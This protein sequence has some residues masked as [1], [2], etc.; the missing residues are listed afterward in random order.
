MSELLADYERK[1]R[2]AVLHLDALGE[3]VKGFT[4]RE[5]GPIKGEPQPNG[6]EYEF[7][8]PPER[9]HPNWQLLIGEFAY[10]MRASL[11]YLITA[12]VRSTGNEESKR[13][14]FP[15]YSPPFGSVTFADVHDWWDSSAKVGKQ[16]E[17]T[18]SGTRAALKQLQPFYGLPVTDHVRH[19]LNALYELN[20]RV[21]HRSLNLIARAATLK[22]ID[23]DG[24]PLFQGL[25]F[26]FRSVPTERNEAHTSDVYLSV[27][28]D[29]TEVD[30][31]LL[32]TE[33][34]AFHQPP[35]LIG[36][37]IETLRGIQEFIDGR[38]LPTVKRLL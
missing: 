3:S 24:K 13:N 28:A 18:P 12:L 6:S 32:A 1:R 17:N 4:E 20:N 9:F 25:D 7:H 14:E 37:V 8:L 16:L 26:P 33:E 22:F 38:V 35:E 10:N 5:R 2:R 29:H 19:P 36:E 21:K 31:Y 15:I 23:A 27:P 30:M 11:D 34:V